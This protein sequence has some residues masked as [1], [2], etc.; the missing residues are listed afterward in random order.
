[1][2]QLL[3]KPVKSHLQREAEILRVARRLE[4][5]PE[6]SPLVSSTVQSTATA[7]MYRLQKTENLLEE[8]AARLSAEVRVKRCRARRK[9]H[10][11]DNTEQLLQQAAETL[12]S[13]RQYS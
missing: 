1:M 12:T 6:L 10:R 4:L 7:K 2:P 11:V 3:C 5:G 13:V 9:L 8:T